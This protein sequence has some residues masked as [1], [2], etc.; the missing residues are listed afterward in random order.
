MLLKVRHQSHREVE[1]GTRMCILINS[2]R[3]SRYLKIGEPL[4]QVFNKRM[5]IENGG[6]RQDKGEFPAGPA[7]IGKRRIIVKD[8]SGAGAYL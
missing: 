1:V 6:V 2:P 5:P 7:S 4:K 3:D 8:G